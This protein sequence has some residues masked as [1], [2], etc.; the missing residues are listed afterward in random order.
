MLNSVKMYFKVLQSRIGH[1]MRHNKQLAVTV[2][3]IVSTLHTHTNQMIQF[4]N[5]D[6]A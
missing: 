5:R 4:F 2:G 3:G 6:Y 1:A